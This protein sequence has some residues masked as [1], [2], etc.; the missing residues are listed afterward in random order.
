[1]GAAGRVAV[2]LPGSLAAGRQ[3]TAIKTTIPAAKR[4]DVCTRRNEPQ[5]AD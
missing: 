4:P 1:M 5:L 2:A 3:P